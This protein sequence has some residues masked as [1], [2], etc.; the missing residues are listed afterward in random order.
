MRL[1][2]SSRHIVTVLVALG[3]MA[4]PP[5]S[6][7]GGPAIGPH[8]SITPASPVSVA[9][10]G[11]YSFTAANCGTGELTWQL[12]GPG[13]I[14]RSGNYSAPASVRAQSLSRGCQQLPNNAPFNIAV[15]QLPV[16]PHSAR[17]MTRIAQD[18]PQYLNTYH[19]LKFYTQI[20]SQ[21]DNV[22]DNNT[23]QEQLHFLYGDRS[24]GYQNAAFPIPAQRDLLMEGGAAVDAAG[25]LDRHLFTINKATCEDTEIYNLYVDFDSVT[26]TPGNPTGVTWTTH[27][28]WPI[29]QGYQV[30]IT[31]GTGAWSAANGTWRVTITGNN[32]GTL[33]FNSSGWG[34]APSNIVMGSTPYSASCPTCNSQGGQKYHPGSYTM[35]GG[36]DAASM[37]MSALALK[38]E[39]WYAAT[40]AGRPDLGHAIRTTMSNAYLAARAIWPAL[41][42][43]NTQW[44]LTNATNGPNPTF[45]ALSDFSGLNAC[46]NYTYT[47]GCQFHVVIFGLTGAW[48]AA[49]GDQTA[50]A[51]D[52]YHFTV[53]ALNTTTWGRFTAGYGVY[54]VPDFMP[55]GATVRLKASFDTNRVCTSTD[56][57]NWCPYAKVYLNTLKKYGMVV[58]DGT[59]PGDNWDNT[60]VSSEFHPNVLVDATQNL[61]ASTAL[62]PIE[63]SL[64]V[65]NRSSQQLSNTP[66][67]WLVTNTGRTVVQVCGS[68][69]CAQNDVILQ[70]TTIGT[71]RE[72]MAVA[73]GTSYQ[74]NVWVNGNVNRHLTYSMDSGISGSYV[75][76]S[77]MVSM[78]YCSTKQRGMITVTSLADSDAL[79]LYIEVNC[80]PMSAD[81]GYRLALGNYS[82]D[83]RDSTGKTWYGSWGNMGFNNSYEA[84]GLF[85]GAQNGSWEGYSACQHDTWTGTDSQLYS[86][87][88]NTNEDTKVELIVPNGTY[89]LTLYGE[90]GF[91]GFGGNN[92]CGNTAGKNVFD[93]QVQGLT[94][95]SWLDG[96]VLAGN[97]PYR[98]YTLTTT[99]TVSNNRLTS[100]GRMRIPSTY[101]MSWSSLLIKPTNTARVPPGH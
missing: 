7:A 52:S 37:P 98:G 12:S 55:Y 19:A 41:G 15:D 93:W 91:G 63:Q 26:F 49:N 39:E 44:I 11:T 67:T 69:G 70:G 68:A 87:S 48:A 72:R 100:V 86:R 79:P 20:L 60:T 38:L 4:A 42:V 96:F 1:L 101:G 88:T 32:S 45:T 76:S 89:Y 50:I 17:W 95:G 29:P 16:D 23:P 47:V 80:I 74:L 85:W 78:P 27:T 5:K 21:Y 18:H 30:F 94:I 99:V 14:D 75:S 71:D 33:P 81:G 3:L 73:A 54:F 13:S 25:W 10:G 34:A 64:E 24:N 62:Q 56:L 36:T 61:R 9:A 65:V 59:T 83:Y 82:G 22:V 43:A 66:S 2:L 58:A 35:M 40:R 90:P 97:Q 92:T 84:P 31:G 28:I 51:V 57:N 53:P 77:G 8:C 46:D 6:S